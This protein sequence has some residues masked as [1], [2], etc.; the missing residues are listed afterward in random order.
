LLHLLLHAEAKDRLLAKHGIHVPFQINVPDGGRDGKWDADIEANEY[1]PKRLTYY[2]CKAQHLTD[3][4]CRAEILRSDQI[5]DIRLKEKVDEVLNQ[6]GA[7]VFFSSHPC[8]KIDERIIAAREALRDAGRTTPE[9]DCIEFLDAN[10]IADWVNLHVSAFAFVCQQVTNWQPVGLRTVEA[11]GDDPIF[12]RVFQPNDYLTGQI[13][14]IREWLIKPQNVARITGPSG[15]GKTRLGYEVFS[16]QDVGDD[17][18]RQVISGTVAYTDAQYYREDVIGWADQLCN[19][20]FSGILVIDN[21]PHEWH[22][23][24]T[25]I[26]RRAGSK[27]SLL[28]LDY[29]PEAIQSDFLHVSLNPQKLRDV[30]PKILKEAPELAHLQDGEIDQ[31]SNFAQGFPQIAILTAQAGRALD[32]AALNYQS[33]LADRLLWGRSTPDQQAREVI[34]CLALFSFVG[35]NGQAKRQLNFIRAKLCKEISEY[36]FNRTTQRFRDMRI[37]QEAGDY[38]MVAPPPLA[39]ALAAEWLGDAPDD[40]ILE[41]LPGIEANGLTRPFCDQLHKLDFSEKATA[42]SK[43]LM[44]ANAPLSSAEVLN[45]EVGSQIFRALSELNP[46]AATECL[47]R[48]FANYSPEQ[49]KSIITGRRNLIWSLEKLCWPTETFSKA[50]M[51]LMALASGENESYGN[52]ATEQFKQLFHI[53]L[54][55]TRCPASDRLHT[56]EHGL[57]SKHIEVN[58]V[59]IE[60][61]DSAL[62]YGHFSRMSGPEVRGTQLPERDWEASNYR[63]IWDYWKQAFYLLHG[64]ILANKPTAELA[65]ERLGR[66]L[67]ALLGNPLAIELENEL[68]VIADSQNGFWPKA[69]ECI[70]DFLR[71]NKNLPSDHRAVVERWLSYVQ[72]KDVKSR[73][74]DIVSIPGW[75]HEETADGKFIDVAQKNAEE[76]A[77]EL[78]RSKVEW[79]QFIPLLL[80][81]EQQQAFFYGARCAKLCDNPHNLIDRCLEVLRSENKTGQNPQLLRGILFA[82]T[83]R[84]IVTAVL[85]RVAVDDVLI[86]LLIPLTTAIRPTIDDFD[87]VVAQVQAG[88]LNPN[89]IQAFA[90]GSVTSGFEDNLFRER[91]EQLVKNIPATAPAVFEIVNLHCHGQPNKR[92]AYRNLIKDLILSPEICTIGRNSMAGYHWQTSTK[93]LLASNPSEDWVRKLTLAIANLAAQKSTMPGVRDNIREIIGILLG[94]YTK[95]AWP[96]FKAAFE[97]EEKS[98]YYFLVKLLTDGGSSFDNHGSPL[99]SLPANELKSLVEAKPDLIPYFLHFMSLYTVKKDENGSEQF[100]WHPHALLLLE[101]G[102]TEDVIGSIHANLFS[103]GSSGSRVPYLE[104]RISLIKSLPTN[105]KKELIQI[106]DVLLNSLTELLEAEQ[107]RDAQHAAGIF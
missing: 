11:W 46:L 6:G 23:Q 66:R 18:V 106:V 95:I 26:A 40:Y 69:R 33:N 4:G 68:K 90:Y 42:L 45:S 58:F 48:I 17:K 101:I 10:K 56:I 81:G 83:D 52:N 28:T 29:V 65:L 61:L 31:I 73:L 85:N 13:R 49:S 44:G 8:V 76:L 51:V 78:Y 80:Q 72:P 88:R 96:I 55:G 107:K 97:N 22:G 59:C 53:Q 47:Y 67:G 60:A 24:L 93:E 1:I 98:D 62:E 34:R 14:S 21:C 12:R 25:S 89:S 20:G 37:I 35:A 2:Q 79:E 32:M 63:E 70:K 64:E 36:D 3:G 15:L 99:W 86:Q 105:N 103:F 71:F 100:C 92:I 39:V 43:R 75:E 7:Y 91:L 38:I 27:L 104:K 57:K 41:L 54:S 82:I 50:S 87:R 74:L 19:F 5:G 94:Q 30:V 9:N 102:K 77:D 84:E 16:F